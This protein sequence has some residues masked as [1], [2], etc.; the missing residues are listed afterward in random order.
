V[1]IILIAGPWSSGTTAVIGALDSLGV[2][3]LGPYFQSNDPRTANTFELIP[4]RKV[5]LRYV[6]ERALR[7]KD[8]YSA[9]FIP[10]LK[11]FFEQAENI[12]RPHQPDR[13]KMLLALKMPLASICLPEIC[14]TI[15]TDLIVVHRPFEEIEATRLRRN[16]GASISIQL[17]LMIFSST[18]YPFSV[19][20]TEIL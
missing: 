4:F 13:E 6:D 8:N 1:K 5:I 16:W 12:M 11:R 3:T 15:K 9:E 2:P 10:A 18:S 7:H 17:C 20:A 19:S 14:A